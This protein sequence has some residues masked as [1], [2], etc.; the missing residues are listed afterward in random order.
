MRNV[1]QNLFGAFFY[2]M[3]G[4]PIALGVFYPFLR[5]M[6]SP[7]LAAI[8]MSASSITVIGNAARLRRWRPRVEAGVAS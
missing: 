3:L 1:Y 5:I 6:L 8:A 2:N 7:I 4:L